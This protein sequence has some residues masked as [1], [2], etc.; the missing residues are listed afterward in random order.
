MDNEIILEMKSIS[1]YFPGVHA[2]EKVDF[3]LRKGEV[4]ALVGE[5][6]A[7]KS[8]L[9]KILAGVYKADEG[10]IWLKGKKISTHGTKDMIGYGISVIYQELNLIP[11]M[12]VGENIFLGREP[13][14]N[15]YFRFI[16]WQ[17]MYT[18]VKEIMDIFNID[19]DPRKKVYTLGIAY[20]QVVEI[21]KALSLQSEILVMDEPTATLTGYETENLF[22]IIDALKKKGVS[23]IYISH[24]LEEI[25]RIADRVTVLRD[26]RKIITD[27]LM[28]LQIDEI[29]KY[30]VGRE[31][32]DK[33]LKEEIVIGNEILG[34]KNLSK[35]GVCDNINFNLKKGEIL[36]I[37]GL[38][39]AGRTEMIQLL[40][41]YQKKDSGI[42]TINGKEVQIKSPY[43]AIKAGIGLIPEERK[44]Q[45]LV[46]CRSVFHNISLSI[47][48]RFSLAGFIKNRNLKEIIDSIINRINIKTPSRKQLVKN[49]SGGNQQKVVLAK[50]F[51]R[52][53]DIYIF[54]EPTRGIDV[55]A[56]IE[57]YQLMS[58]LVKNGAGIIMISSELPEILNISDRIIVMYNGMIVKKFNK[59]EATQESIL[60]YAFGGGKGSL[61]YA[62]E[63]LGEV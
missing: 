51:S 30:M 26:S 20:Q 47:L 25:R 48:D 5:N 61:K 28:N 27:N 37:A 17:Q 40:F 8:T 60:R 35:K 55:G 1:K 54:D 12:S 3:D 10:E 23:I 14:K 62:K 15:N 46:L 56:K 33:Y 34:V 38:V 45:G 22:N 13:I 2:L 9:I 57:I 4:H 53:C 6:G 32:K 63:M 29:I 42:I 16:N 36:G 19:L 41:G 39:G 31:L 52:N 43:D 59:G 49:L 21:A 11:H 7:G 24:R 58:N 18:D 44:N 50:W